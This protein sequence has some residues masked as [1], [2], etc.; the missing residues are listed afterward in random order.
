[1]IMVKE[2]LHLL[3]LF[4]GC[5]EV[6]KAMRLLSYIYF[7]TFLLQLSTLLLVT[8]YSFC[9]FVVVIVSFSCDDFALA[10]RI[11]SPYIGE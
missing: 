1:V 5:M 4:W 3:S 10:M 9:G 8:C 7:L 6:F 2:L 11:V